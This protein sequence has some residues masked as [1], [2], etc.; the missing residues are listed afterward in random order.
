MFE[1]AFEDSIEGFISQW[2]PYAAAVQLFSRTE[3]N[4][5]LECGAAGKIFH[6]LERTGP[7]Q[8]GPGSAR[9]I[10]SAA[11][12]RVEKAAET[13]KRLEVTGLSKIHAQGPVLLRQQRTVVV[14]AGIPLVVGVFAGLPDDVAAG[15]WLEF[16]SLPPLHG[17]VVS[18]GQRPLVSAQGEEGL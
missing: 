16:T 18:Q 8:V 4:P 7:Y 13:R 15:D 3:G 5:L 9:I 10:V 1:T 14:D 17:F 6:V 11:A 2:K 12:E